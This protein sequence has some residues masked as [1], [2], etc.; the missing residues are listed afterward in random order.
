MCLPSQLSQISIDSDQVSGKLNHDIV[1]LF[2]MLITQFTKISPSDSFR[3][4][5]SQILNWEQSANWDIIS[6]IDNIGRF[7][8]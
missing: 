5:G 8:M 4:V 7:V 6:S 2:L 1:A 3:G